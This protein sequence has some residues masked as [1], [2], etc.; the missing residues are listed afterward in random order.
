MDESE[1]EE[2]GIPETKEQQELAVIH[3]W[4]E[5]GGSQH[6]LRRRHGGYCV[7]YVPPFF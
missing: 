6:C 3:S 2:V 4:M 1:E 5:V 7:S